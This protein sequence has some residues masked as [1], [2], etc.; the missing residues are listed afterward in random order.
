M[1]GL[2]NLRRSAPEMLDDSLAKL[3][4]GFRAEYSTAVKT[5]TVAGKAQADRTFHRFQFSQG[6]DQN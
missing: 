2:S 5:A 4:W 3:S 6:F 1:A